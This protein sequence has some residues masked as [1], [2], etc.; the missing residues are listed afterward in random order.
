MQLGKDAE[1]SAAEIFRRAERGIGFRIRKGQEAG[2]RVAPRGSLKG[3]P[4][5]P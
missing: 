4:F 3:W 5:G 1:L 2:D